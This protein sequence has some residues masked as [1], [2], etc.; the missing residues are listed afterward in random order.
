MTDRRREHEPRRRPN[1]GDRGRRDLA[2]PAVAVGLGV[3]LIVLVAAIWSFLPQ[4]P[5]T[6]SPSPRGSGAV[7]GASTSPGLATQ[8]PTPTTPAAAVPTDELPSGRPTGPPA[9]ELV[10]T[11][12]EAFLI[13]GALRRVGPCKPKRDGL[14]RRAIAG[15]SCTPRSDLVQRVELYRY[16]SADP[17]YRALSREM[18]DA[19]FAEE[20]SCFEGEPGMAISLPGET[21]FSEGCYVNPRGRA[22]VLRADGNVW[23]E[24]SYFV[25]GRVIGAG[26]GIARL[27]DWAAG[28]RATRENAPRPVVL[29][30]PEGSSG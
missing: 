2:G 21:D 25:F 30:T 8:G 17:M 28:G 24:G 13:D 29:W 3:V 14:P 12:D 11:T 10:P 22:V 9:T 5:P 1:A 27:W 23:D 4:G 18:E 7:A 15:V 20:G 6:G 19:G 26:D 16:Q